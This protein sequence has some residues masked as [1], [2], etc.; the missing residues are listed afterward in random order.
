MEYSV[1]SKIQGFNPT[2]RRPIIYCRSFSA[3][4]AR[5]CINPGIGGVKLYSNF[6]PI[7]GSSFTTIEKKIHVPQELKTDIDGEGETAQS[8]TITNEMNESERQ[9]ILDSL[10]KSVK[11]KL[12]ENIYKSILHP[13]GIRTGKLLVNQKT[14]TEAKKRQSNESSPRE[15]PDIKKVKPNSIKHKFQFV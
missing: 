9:S 2:Y 11:D 6:V 5:D 14:E 3:Y 13:G 4:P 1:F 8:E 15:Q 12:P 10:N 7:Y